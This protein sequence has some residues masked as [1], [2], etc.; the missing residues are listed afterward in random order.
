MKNTLLLV[1]DE[2]LIQEMVADFF[3]VQGWQTACFD[4]GREAL[5]YLQRN[6]V[7]MVLLD[8]MIPGMN[9]F[10]VC[11]EIRKNMEI[12]VIF[13]TALEAE[14]MQLR[15]YGCGADD[16]IT[17]PFSLPVLLAKVNALAQRTSKDRKERILQKGILTLNPEQRKVTAS[18]RE[19]IMADK[20]YQ[21]LLYFMENENRVLSREQILNQVWGVDAEILDRVVDKHIV[22]LRQALGDAGSYIRTVSKAGYSFQIQ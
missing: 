15:G 14:N 6:E 16:Y 17:K 8:V 12:P 1:E 22:K 11:K 20:E 21:L 5:A 9:G 19:C 2:I 10:E 7:Q 18:G 3:T 4:N 13:L